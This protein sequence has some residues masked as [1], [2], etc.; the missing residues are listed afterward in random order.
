[1]YIIL[2]MDQSNAAVNTLAVAGDNLQ[3][4]LQPVMGIQKQLAIL[5][6]H[7]S[8]IRCFL[9]LLYPTTDPNKSIL[10]KLLERKKIQNYIDGNYI[11]SIIV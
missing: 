2:S 3:P 8:R 6:S 7:S 11:S 1:M 4:S 5:F 9:D 10:E